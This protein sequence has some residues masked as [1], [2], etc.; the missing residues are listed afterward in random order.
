MDI[1]A[2]TKHGKVK[3]ISIKG[4][5]L[6]FAGI[7]F[8]KP[9]VGA[10]RFK[11]PVDLEPWTGIKDATKFGPAGIQPYDEIETASHGPQSEDCLHL[12]IWTQGIDDDNKRPVMVWIHGGG[13]YTGGTNDPLYDGA[14][15]AER[16]D[17]VL[18][19]IQYRLGALGW[20]YLDELGGKDFRYSKN[21]GLLDQVAALRWVKDNISNFGGDPDNITIFGQSAGGASVSTLMVTPSAKGLFNK[22]IAQSGTFHHSLTQKD[23]SIHYTKVFMEACGVDDIDGLMNLSEEQIRSAMYDISEEATF[24]ADWMLRPTFDGD[25]LPE[26]PYDYIAEGN[27]SDILLMHGSTKDEYHYWLYYYEELMRSTPREAMMGL[28]KHAYHLSDSKID[29]L[30]QCLSE[31]YPEKS[32]S[33]NYIDIAT[34]SHFRYPHIRISESQSQHGPTWEYLFEWSSPIDSEKGAYHGIDLPFV[35]Y[36]EEDN[37]FGEN[38]P[39]TLLEQVQNAWISFARNGDPS[40]SDLPAWPKYNIEEKPTMV[41]NINPRVE[42]DPDGFLRKKLEVVMGKT[43]EAFN[44]AQPFRGADT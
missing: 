25:V 22:V 37:I 29:E 8:A 14:S 41:F 16:G 17:V 36:I 18:V 12:N 24:M 7:P 44:K 4:N 1:I 27:T 32:V 28:Y 31:Y 11:A 21:I 6:R 9:P 34:L 30:Y 10:L 13:F 33:D 38:P 26:D 19:S 3:G 35:F 23:R 20:L 43:R 15:L 5:V 42:N 40:H 2:N 39:V